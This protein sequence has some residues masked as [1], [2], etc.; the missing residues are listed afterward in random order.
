MI[1]PV[2]GTRNPAPAAIT[3]SRTVTLKFSGRPRSLGLSVNEAGVLAIHIG[4]FWYPSFSMEMRSLS[5]F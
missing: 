4:R 1:S 5:A 2:R 3:I